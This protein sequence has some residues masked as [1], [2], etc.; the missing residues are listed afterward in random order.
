MTVSLTVMFSPCSA[1]RMK[2]LTTRPSFMCIRGPKVLKIRATLTCTPSWENKNTFTY[3][4]VYDYKLYIHVHVYVPM[5]LEAFFQFF[6]LSK[7]IPFHI[8]IPR[9]NLVLSYVK[10]KSDIIIHQWYMT[11]IFYTETWN[12]SYTIADTWKHTRSYTLKQDISYVAT[13]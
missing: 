7:F 8:F 3:Q 10:L 9:C 13:Q 2:L 1:C 12:K 5:H 11:S 4:T 6:F